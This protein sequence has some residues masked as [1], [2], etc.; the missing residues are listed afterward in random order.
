MSS[1]LPLSTLLFARTLGGGEI[2]CA[3]VADGS[4]ASVGEEDD[5]LLEQRIC[6]PEHLGGVDAETLARF[7]VPAGTRLHVA[8]VLVPRED[9]PRKLAL[10][11][12]IAIPAVVVPAG[13]TTVGRPR[14]DEVRVRAE[15]WL[16]ILPLGYTGYDAVDERFPHEGESDEALAASAEQLVDRHVARA[17][18]RE[19]LRLWTARSEGP[20]AW[21]GLSSG[22]RPRLV[23]LALEL[24]R[25]DAGPSQ[26]AASLRRALVENE[27]RKRA[28]EILT[29]VARPV[30]LAR[31]RF[32]DDPPP[33]RARERELETLASLLG[34]RPIG[35]RRSVVLVGRERVGKTALLPAWLD[36]AQGADEGGRGDAPLVYATSGA[37]L[38]AGMSGLGQWQERVRRVC[39][40]AAELDAVLWF[41]DLADL[42]GERGKST[43]DVPAALRPFV[44]QGR[45]RLVGEIGEDAIDRA[46]RRSPGFFAALARVRVPALDAKATLDALRA[47]A[48]W[49]RRHDPDGPVLD[50]AALPPIVDLAER[51]LPYESFPG[52]ALRLYEELRATRASAGSARARARVSVDDVYEGTS[53]RTGVP[54][55]LLRED[56]ALVLDD[57][58]AT[59]RRRVIGQDEAVRRVAET[60]CVVKA[61]LQPRGKPLST[62]LFVGPTGV[63]KTE[64]AR[65]LAGLLFGA[66]HANA[67]D[68]E[69]IA[70]FD[71]SEYMDPLAADRLIRGD[72][73]GEGVL[74]RRVR[75]QPFGVLLLDEIEKAHPRVF[76]LLLQV[77]GE[78]RLTDAAGRT[79]YFHNAIVIMTSNLGA[80]ERRP[81]V[82][83]ERPDVGG[84]AH[85][86]RAVTAA[87]RPEL[88]NRIDRIVA[89]DELGPEHRRTLASLA[90]EKVRR[91]R[92]LLESGAALTVSDAALE[93]L[94]AGGYDPRYGARALRRHVEDRLVAPLARLLSSYGDPS[95]VDVDVRALDEASPGAPMASDETDQLRLSLRRRGATRASHEHVALRE[96]SGMRREIARWTRLDRIV[97]LREQVRFL[98]AQLGYGGNDAARR[99]REAIDHGRLQ[100][101]HHRFDRLLADLDL[102]HDEAVAVEDRAIA[103]FLRADPL[104]PLLDEARRHRR[105][106]A[107]PLVRALVAQ[108]PRR[109]EISLILQELDDGRALEAYLPGLVQW[110]SSHRLATA[111]HVHRGEKREGEEWPDDR[112]WGPPR[113]VAEARALARDRERKPASILLR[114][115]GPDA[116]LLSFEAGLHR[117]RGLSAETDPCHL[118]VHLVALRATFGDGEWKKLEPDPPTS[119]GERIRGATARLHDHENARLHVAGRTWLA[120]A[121]RDYWASF[122]EVLLAHLLLAERGLIPRDL[123]G[124][125]ATEVDEIRLLLEKG[126][127][128]EAIKRY[129]ALTGCSLV[130]AKRYVDALEDR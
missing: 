83:F 1:S 55:F 54:P 105:A 122:D 80:T 10:R 123:Q 39:E 116:V 76:D 77:C 90:I 93:R 75:E 52:K 62:F 5:A 84:A 119:A 35:D 29:S 7:S 113:D 24:D 86:L 15:R 129:R 98:V 66:A 67:A 47:R 115:T 110:A 127:K 33:L 61:G 126:E 45:V 25:G 64:L 70:R 128:I 97:E 73:H 13:P 130:D 96:I 34:Q 36:R 72:D 81:P 63:G 82:G 50:D 94:A 16:L 109:D 91:R 9:L 48:S 71:M 19:T 107:G 69:R 53:T 56:R 99:G 95:E 92:G 117:F 6:L 14:P 43:V 65:A 104:G 59:L 20:L 12:K 49:D 120:I 18:E 58:I 89:F 4:L 74:T 27:R 23:E 103:A 78:G 51:Y 60:V 30:H 118:L 2:V 11:T 111:V 114:I 44:E 88:L 26:R 17:I 37:A 121:P 46:E 102:L 112:C 101:D 21:L 28:V 42:F 68:G 41:D 3:P 79:A 8:D 57:V 108:E 40:A 32:A 124:R 22:R 100:A 125:L 87:F 106:F 38:V 85:Y 31:K